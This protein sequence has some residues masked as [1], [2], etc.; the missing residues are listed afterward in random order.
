MKELQSS[1]EDSVSARQ[2]EIPG[3][4]FA[5][6]FVFVPFLVLF[7][8]V[9]M[10]AGAIPAISYY[11]WPL[12]ADFEAV[13]PSLFRGYKVITGLKTMIFVL[14]VTLCLESN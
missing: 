5:G 2:N 3:C 6:N 4:F 9:Y 1:L 10:Y 13:F 14:S 11:V 7:Q 8:L 12:S